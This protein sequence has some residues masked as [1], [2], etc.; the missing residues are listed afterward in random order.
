MQ[1]L[2]GV[3]P[4]TV[5]SV[6]IRGIKLGSSDITLSYLFYADDVV[7]TFEYNSRDLDNIMR[8]V[9]VFHPAFGLKINIHESNIYGIGVSND[10]VSSMASRTGCAAG[11][12]P[13]TYLGLQ[14]GSNINLMSSWNILVE[15]FQKRLL[16]YT[17][18]MLKRIRELERVNMRLRDMMDVTS[19][20]VTWSQCRELCV[21]REL[22]HIRPF[23][24]Y[25]RVRIARLEACARRHLGYQSRATMTCEAVNEHIDRRL[26]GALGAPDAARNPKLLM[27]NEENGNGG[28]GNGGNE[29]EKYQV[30]FATCTLL[31]NALTWWNSHKRTIGIEAAY[32]MSWAK[33]IKLVTEVYCP[34]NEELVLQCTRM[35]PNEED[36]VERFVGG[37]PD[38]IQGNVI[39]VEPTKLQDAI[40]IAN[41]LMDQ[42]L[43]EYARSAKKKRLENN[44]RD[45]RGQQLV[46]KR[47]NVRD[48][49]MERAY[50]ARNNV[51]K[52]LETRMG[53]R[54]EAMKLQRRL[55]PLEEEEQTPILTL[56]RKKV[57]AEHHIMCE[58]PE[59]YSKGMSSLSSASY[60]QED[61]DKSEEKR[62]EDVPVIREFSKVF[63]EDFPRLPPAQQVEFQID[64][65]LGAA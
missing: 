42:K 12:F 13:F 19:Q 36:K 8:V 35:V 37:L 21:Q 46:F 27:G 16:L 23:R 59:V 15:R 57:E 44:L 4:N 22:R 10:E 50:T 18:D 38:N 7:I 53:T 51:K 32:A 64:L 43:K 49:N 29:N 24:F 1:G 61:W 5:N 9:C 39:D 28:N 14:I 6:L 62:L 47:Q 3:M 33:L 34:R 40:P 58:D 45:N 30:K 63:L 2:H 60:I 20:R 41:N 11:S 31:N 48:H 65:V 54:L 56:S 52:R 25:D 17:T 26:A 55:M